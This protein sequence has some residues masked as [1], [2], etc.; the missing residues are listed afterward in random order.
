MTAV[1]ER[2]AVTKHAPDGRI[3]EFIK[4]PISLAAAE[5]LCTQAAEQNEN[6]AAQLAHARRTREALDQAQLENEQIRQRL[7]KQK[8]EA[9]REKAKRVERLEAELQRRKVTFAQTD[10]AI[11]G[12]KVGQAIGRAVIASVL[13]RRA[14]FTGGKVRLDLS[15]QGQACRDGVDQTKNRHEPAEH[16]I[17][18]ASFDLA[19]WAGVR[20]VIHDHNLSTEQ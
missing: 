3:A 17:F 5:R 7:L 18:A 4:C 11:I 14:E 6:E 2:V 20:A 13:E 12:D 16:V 9:L 15:V 10:G 19:F 1:A 8:E